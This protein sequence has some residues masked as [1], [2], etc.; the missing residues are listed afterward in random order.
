M[1]HR[2]KEAV[3]GR[4]NLHCLCSHEQTHGSIYTGVTGRLLERFWEHKT[5]AKK[6]FAAKYNLDK[7]VYY[8]SFGDPEFAI[9]REKEIKGWRREK[10]VRLIEKT[11]PKWKD[12]PVGLLDRQ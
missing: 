10:K 5:K 2:A 7:L 6:G 9:L 8:E 11:N 1:R 3:N 4:Q 12:L